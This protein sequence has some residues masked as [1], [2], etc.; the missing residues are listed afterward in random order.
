MV[1]PSVH[2]G[3]LVADLL[4]VAE[5]Q[6][7]VELLRPSLVAWQKE[8]V[9]AAESQHVVELLR[10]SLVAWQKELVPAAELKVMV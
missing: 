5:S 7:V 3:R 6:H 2:Q 9:P 4:A 8:L 10:P 1:L